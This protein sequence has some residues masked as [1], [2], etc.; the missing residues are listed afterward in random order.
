MA[1]RT[2]TIN[3]AD[4]DSE[5]YTINRDKF[6]GV[7]EMSIDGSTVTVDHTAKPKAQSKETTFGGS[8]SITVKREIEPLLS[9]VVGGASAAYSLRDLNDKAGNNKVVRV[10]RT[11]DNSEKDFRAKEVKDIET[12]VNAQTVLPLDIQELEAD[13]RTG[14]VVE[15]A[16]AYSLRNLSASY[17]GDVVDVRRS[18]DDAEESFTAAEVF[19]GTLEDWVAEEQVGWNLQPTWDVSAGDGV[20]SSQSST[21][22]TSTFSVTTTSGTSFVRQSSKPN[23]IIA[24][25]G[26]Q[27]VANITLSGFDESFSA[28]LRTSGT[29]TNVAQQTVRNGTA[30]YTFTLTGSAGYFAFTGIEATSGATLTVNS[31]KVIG[32]SGFVSQWYDQSG[33]DN[34]ATQGTDAS[35]PKIVSGGS[36]VSGGLDFN[37]DFLV[38]S[39]VSGL[40]GSLSMFSLSERDFSGSIVSLSNSSSGSRY[41]SIQEGGSS[42]TVNIRNTTTVNAS[43]N[44]SSSTRLTFASTTGATLTSVGSNG[45]AVTTTSSDYGDDFSGTDINQIAI[46]LLRTVNP[47]SYFN[48][49]IQEIIIYDSDQSANRTAFEANIGETYGIDLPSGVDT[50]YDQ[51]DG[52]VETW[53][54]QS[55]NGND[56]TQLTA[57]YQPKIVDAGV[58]LGE[59]D[60]RDGTQ[61]FLETTNSNLCNIPELSVF[62]VLKAHTAQSRVNAFGCGAIVSGSTGYGGW[63]MHFNGYFDRGYF[64]TQRVGNGTVSDLTTSV[65]SGADILLSAT[66]NYPV[67]SFYK[68]GQNVA[69]KTDMLQ[70]YNGDAVRRRFRIGCQ[71]AS[72]IISHYTQPIK[73]IILYTSDQS[74]NRP[75]IEANINNQYDIY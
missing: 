42:S 53:Y 69:N 31:I 26:D 18:S 13:G 73:E 40:T 34:H 17:T 45:S 66:A 14:A 16:A 4:G 37:N 56:A 32:Q 35:Q 1:D 33:N 19:D 75:A 58:Y 61:T 38:A 39:S 62:T 25:S 30:D 3:H 20:I 27:V 59:V 24:S 68:D 67:A 65:V 29:N 63:S 21:S 70:P 12:W 7:R 50:G 49:R 72:G 28:R 11:S 9:E 6:A 23:H 22:T 52:F 48:G 15:A 60:F 54:D 74:A 8:K 41:F 55:G 46:G 36:L 51:V 10:R 71:Y 43:S 47:T 5:T 64:S 44:A 57:S 2:L